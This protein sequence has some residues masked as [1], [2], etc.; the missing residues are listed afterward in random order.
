MKVPVGVW[1][2]LVAL[3]SVVSPTAAQDAKPSEWRRSD[4]APHVPAAIGFTTDSDGVR[5]AT[6][7]ARAREDRPLPGSSQ[8]FR[9]MVF[10]TEIR[11]DDRR[12]RILGGA[13]HATDYSLVLETPE[14]A[15]APLVR[16]TPLHA[17]VTDVCEGGHTG[18]VDLTTDDT[19]AVQRWLV[20]D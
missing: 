6:I 14:V 2:A 8:T 18:P 16:Q 1:A 17:A 3:T 5:Y 19:V 4:L 11:C 10:R 7:V 13:Y 9:G 12:W 15:W 20:G